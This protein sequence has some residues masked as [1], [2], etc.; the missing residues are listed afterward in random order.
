MSTG[1]DDGVTTAAAAATPR[2]ALA[3]LVEGTELEAQ[4]CRVESVQVRS[5]RKSGAEFLVGRLADASGT[6]DMIAFNLSGDQMDAVRGAGLV[7]VSGAAAVHG[8][9]LQFNARRIEPAD[10][11]LDPADRDLLFPRT[12]RDIDAM[13][14]DVRGHLESLDHPGMRAIARSYLDDESIMAGLRTAPAATSNHHAWLGGL[15]EHTWELMEMAA[16]ILGPPAS[17]AM[18]T[19]SASGSGHRVFPELNRDIVMLSVFLHDLDKVHELHWEGE[20]RYTRRGNLVGHLV[21]GAIDL[22][23]R[24]RELR[25]QRG[26][27]VPDAV[28][29]VL[30]HGLV[31]H[32]GRLEYGSAKVPA[33]PEAIFVAQLDDLGAKTSMGLAAADRAS[34]PADDELGLS[35]FTD[36]HWTLGTRIH[37]P[38]PVRAWR[39][40]DAPAGDSA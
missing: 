30:V 35:A 18:A 19:T 32:H 11:E 27:D 33:T 9:R 34:A 17:A 38:D 23:R 25:N 15:L 36:P 8:G 26:I 21:G 10:G 7:R 14:D 16:A 13:L 28:V 12:G 3:A 29:D 4:I 1:P 24:V 5:S 40:P 6:V 39:D 20:F 37:R 2:T 31:S 22:E